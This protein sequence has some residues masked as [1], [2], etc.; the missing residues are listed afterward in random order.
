MWIEHYIIV[1]FVDTRIMYHIVTCFVCWMSQVLN[2]QAKQLRH[3]SLHLEKIVH[4]GRSDAY[5]YAA[6]YAF[7]AVTIDEFHCL[8]GTRARQFTSAPEERER[9]ALI[10][11]QVRSAHFLLRCDTFPSLLFFFSAVTC[12]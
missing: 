3:L 5:T 7:S 10:L 8:E 6:Y 9:R 12:R 2:P 1:D 11:P 4:T